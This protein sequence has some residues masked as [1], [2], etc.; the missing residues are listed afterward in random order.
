MV[1]KEKIYQDLK[2]KGGL[3]ELQSKHRKRIK[4]KDDGPSNTVKLGQI[5][6]SLGQAWSSSNLRQRDAV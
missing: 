5:Q 6:S 4:K 3:D 2:K 1:I